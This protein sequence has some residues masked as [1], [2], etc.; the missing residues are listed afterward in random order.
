MLNN[1]LVRKN[2]HSIHIQFYHLA[3][4]QSAGLKDLGRNHGIDRTCIKI[5]EL[6]IVLFS[7]IK[8]INYFTRNVLSSYFFYFYCRSGKRRSQHR[9]I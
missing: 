2:V 5:I 8:S 3:I 1:V 9:Y 6:A 4:W 7:C